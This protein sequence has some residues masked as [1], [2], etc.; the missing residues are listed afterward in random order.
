MKNLKV[1][2]FLT[3]MLPLIF[4]CNKKTKFGIFK[5]MN[6]KKTIEMNGVI[7]KSSL[8]NFEKLVKKYGKVNRINI[9]NCPGSK[10]DETNLKLSKKVH[11][12]G[13]TIHILDNGEI[14]SGGVDFFLAGTKRTKGNNTKIGVHSWSSGNGEVATDF[15]VGHAN[16]IPYINYY[17]SV[18]FTQEQAE[19][20]YYFTINSAPAESVH[21]MTDAE[22]SQYHILK[23]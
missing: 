1:I 18:G 20:F 11:E 3:A 23:P 4:S 22:I 10:D 19:N 16:H 6:D 9:I 5:V 7:K 8:K 21:W 12:K 14:A 15:P 17:V 13:M 2:L